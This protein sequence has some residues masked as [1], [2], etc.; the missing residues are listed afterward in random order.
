MPNNTI[1]T[2]VH[3][4]ADVA[5]ADWADEAEALAQRV[6]N[7]LRQPTPAKPQPVLPDEYEP[8]ALEDRKPSGRLVKR[9]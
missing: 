1:P 4:S 9:T 6:T 8:Q 2:S 7:K 5:S 3:R